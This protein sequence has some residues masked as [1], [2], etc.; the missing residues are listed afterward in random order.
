MEAGLRLL[1]GAMVFFE[2]RDRP[3]GRRAGL[4]VGRRA[5]ILVIH[6]AGFGIEVFSEVTKLLLGLWVSGAVGNIATLFGALAE[7]VRV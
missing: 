1:D 2:K 7:F 6:V 5:A 3:A 4:G